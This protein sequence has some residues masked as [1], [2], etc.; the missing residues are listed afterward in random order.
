MLIYV[1]THDL[2]IGIQDVRVARRPA[3]G[4]NEYNSSDR[5][6]GRTRRPGSLTCASS[7][8]YMFYMFILYM[9]EYF[10]AVM[11]PLSYVICLYVCFYVPAVR[12]LHVL[13]VL[14]VY[15]RCLSICFICSFM[16]LYVFVCF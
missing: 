4:A 3:P 16:F 15:T 6:A 10:P 2:F 7:P 1:L 13:Y 14:D 5:R 12:C 8:V 9:S 11:S